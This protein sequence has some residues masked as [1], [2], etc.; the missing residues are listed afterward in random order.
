MMAKNKFLII[1]AAAS[2]L[3][4]ASC[5]SVAGDNSAAASS[6]AASSTAT[7]SSSI[8]SSS[9]LTPSTSS[10]VTSASTSDGDFAY[11]LNEEG[12]AYAITGY[13]GQGG[14]V[15]IPASH[16]GKPV[17]SLSDWLFLTDEGNTTLAEVAIP[18]S[19]TQLGEGCFCDCQKLAKVTFDPEIALEKIPASC[20]ALD[21]LLT[22]ITIPASVKSIGDSVSPTST[23]H[24]SFGA[25]SESGLRSVHFAEN[26]SL[27]YI[28]PLAFC[29]EHLTS[30]SL[31]ASV[32]KIDFYGFIYSGLTSVT[33]A[34]DSQLNE[35]GF[36]AFD[37][38]KITSFTIPSKVTAIGLSFI[39]ENTVTTLVNES[40]NFN[41]LG[42]GRY[43]TDSGGALL[44]VVRGQDTVFAFPEGIK[45]IGS[46]AGNWPFLPSKTTSVSFPSSLVSIEEAAFEK[47]SS[48][49]HADFSLA[50][51]L[52]T[53]GKSAFC[54]TAITSLD[55]SSVSAALKI[56]DYA[57]YLCSALASAELPASLTSLGNAVFYDCKALASIS[58]P[59][60]LTGSIGYR[61]FE[62]CSSLTQ[63]VI[64]AG[65][66]SIGSQAFENCSALASVELPA[67]LTSL[68]DYVFDDCQALA[69]LTY[70]GT[71][72]D[73]AKVTLGHYWRSVSLK[74]VACKDGDVTL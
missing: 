47:L 22:D 8:P 18:K 74:V 31:P 29:C 37:G 19:I 66:S 65:V 25:F 36:Q 4:L 1:L 10:E 48:L 7:G 23:V 62:N 56:D 17:T 34:P 2:L 5:G 16:E 13:T 60:S 9:S 45:S 41:L 21:P 49:S 52:T 12:T 70:D 69:T 71:M 61:A 44:F 72:A 64:P 50:K 39:P 27:E 46:G 24:V 11:T 51:S 73:W 53:I 43:L 3:S 54:G 38:T 55:L 28:G 42:S 20:F 30:I 35:I 14:S 67:S 33:F 6:A 63:I 15:Q 59:A 57:F 68:G 26:S 40:P 58:L 32:K